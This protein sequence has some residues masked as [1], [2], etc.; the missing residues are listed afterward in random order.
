[1]SAAGERF[2]WARLMEVGL[3]RLKLSPRDFWQSTPREIAAAFGSPRAAMA[4]PDLEDLMRRHPD[5]P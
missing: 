2:P 5:D 3:G 1:M 4:R